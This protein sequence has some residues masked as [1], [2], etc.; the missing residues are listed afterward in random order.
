MTWQ[1]RM[2]KNGAIHIPSHGE[3][4][5]ARRDHDS[6]GRLYAKLTPLITR[7]ATSCAAATIRIADRP[8]P[9]GPCVP[10]VPL[11]Q[12]HGH[13]RCHVVGGYRGDAGVCGSRLQ[14]NRGWQADQSKAGSK[15]CIKKQEKLEFRRRQKS[16]FEMICCQRPCLS[17]HMP[18]QR[19]FT[20]ACFVEWRARCCRRQVADRG[21]RRCERRLST[22]GP[23]RAKSESSLASWNNNANQRRNKKLSDKNKTH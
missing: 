19:R 6:W 1:P 12:F 15:L 14:L 5:Q 18:C 8:S 9:G 10:C 4:L 21:A 16:H 20:E 13:R 2:R 23:K 17:T 11:H 3:E 22:T 7:S